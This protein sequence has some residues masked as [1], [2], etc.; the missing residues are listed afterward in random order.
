MTD[1]LPPPTES[2][3]PWY[4]TPWGTIGLTL[5][6]I[7][8][9]A[10]VCWVVHIWQTVP[11]GGGFLPNRLEFLYTPFLILD[12]LLTIPIAIGIFSFALRY[13]G[14]TLAARLSFALILFALTMFAVYTV[15]AV[16]CL[17]S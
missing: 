8:V 17:L 5:Y 15:F 2:P 7:A 9:T 16:V 11:S 6:G 10:T 14:S 13:P 3:R 12:V 4:R 1:R